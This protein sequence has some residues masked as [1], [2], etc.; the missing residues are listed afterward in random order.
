MHMRCACRGYRREE[1]H[2]W[3]HWGETPNAGRSRG[4]R[5]AAH[6]RLPIRAHSPHVHLQVCMHNMFGISCSHAQ[7]GNAGLPSMPIK[8][9]PG[10][11]RIPRPATHAVYALPMHA[12]LPLHQSPPTHAHMHMQMA[13]K[14]NAACSGSP[15]ATCTVRHGGD[16]GHASLPWDAGHSMW[17]SQRPAGL[18][19]GA[20]LQLQNTP[21][22]TARARCAQQPHPAQGVAVHRP[23]AGLACRCPPQLSKCWRCGRCFSCT[24]HRTWPAA[25][26]PLPATHIGARLT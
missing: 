23:V 3:G 6:R 4:S 21:C 13:P 16:A 8:A 17:C 15:S 11:P 12:C 2:V 14:H 25:S 20:P 22:C 19:P 24:L 26:V 5:A 9:F 7:A 18:R 10:Q 1:R